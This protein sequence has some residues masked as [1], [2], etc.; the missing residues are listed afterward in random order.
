M[1]DINPIYN[2]TSNKEIQLSFGELWNES[3]VSGNQHNLVKEDANNL[4]YQCSS[5]N[6]IVPGTLVQDF[7]TFIDYLSA[8]SIQLTNKMEHISRKHLPEINKRITVRNETATA[9]TEQIYYPYIHFFYFLALSGRLFE[10]VLG[11][12]GKMILHPTE[13]I[14]LYK[15]LTDI[16]KYFFLLE[17]F[18][19]DVNWAKLLDRSDNPLIDS[20]HELFFICTQEKA[21]KVISLRNNNRWKL[22]YRLYDW[23]FFYLYFEWFGFW[24]CEIDQESV[25]LFGNKSNYFAKSIKLTFL[26]TK[27]IPILLLDRYIQIWNVSERRIYGEI[28]PIPGSKLNEIGYIDLPKKERNI[29]LKKMNEDQ[30]SQPFFLPFQQLFP[31]ESL[32]STLPRNKRRFT[33][34]IYTFKVTFEKNIWRKVILSSQ[35]TMEDLHDIILEAYDFDNDHLY[36][37]FMDGEKWSMDCISSPD[38]DSEG[39][40]ADK[41]QVGDL[42]FITGQRFL[43]LYD[44]GDEWQFLIE[45]EDIKETNPES[46]QPYLKESKGEGPEQYFFDE[47]WFE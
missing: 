40:K 37:F 9:Y 33:K 22:P 11:K 1:K 12:G 19:V 41:V 25:D 28:N 36:S 8:H 14:A 44:Y 27:L 47:D 39:P 30:S 4:E 29:I 18:W 32:Q 38:D 10:K 17:T 3:E 2:K 6:G 5:I 15:K 35:H 7:E 16:E 42:G 31:K 13:R 21:G 46:F 20:L 26:G 34:G 43:Y 23:N 24:Q 45:V